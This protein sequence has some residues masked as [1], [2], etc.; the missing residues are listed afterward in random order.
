[1]DM[2]EAAQSQA[3]HQRQLALKCFQCE[4]YD[5]SKQ[6]AWRFSCATCG[7]DRCTYVMFLLDIDIKDLSIS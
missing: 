7:H 5:A 6:P 4:C 1:M 2:C 3:S